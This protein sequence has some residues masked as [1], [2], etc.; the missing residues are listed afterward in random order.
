MSK[1]DA[2]TPPN[3]I[4]TA[5]AATSTNVG[6][7][8]ANSYLNNVNQNTP[9][10][11][12]SYDQTGTYKYTDPLTNASY[13]IPRFTATQSLTPDQT[14]IQQNTQAAQYNLSQAG[15]NQS[16][17]IGRLLDTSFD[18]VNMPWV[19]QGGQASS[20][21][22]LP[23]AQTSFDQGGTIRSNL[24]PSGDI[25]QTYGTDF[26]TDRQRVEDSLMA[27]MNPQ[28][29]I[30]KQALEQQLADQG[31]RY[32]SQAY[33]DAMLTNS[34]QQNDARW[35][36]ISQAGQEQQRMTE[37]EAQ[38]AAF[39]NAAQQQG[40]EQNLGTGS[41][42][43]QAQAQQFQQNAALGT[44]ANAGLAQQVAQ[45]QAGFN[46]SQAAR[47]SAMQEQY[48]Q[49]NQPI[50][51]ISALL[52]GSQVTNPN[53]INTPG[54][55]IPTTDVAGLINNQFSQQMSVY[56]QQ[57]QNFNSLM[58]GVLGLGAG[59]LKGGYLSDRREKDDIDRIATV[60]AASDEGEKKELPIYQYSYKDDPAST[61]HVGP[62][63]QDVEKIKPSAVSNVGGKKYIKPAQ[64]MGSILRAA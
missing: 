8:I 64:V 2:P 4:A 10:G 28:L 16:Y 32:G 43:N 30:Q 1:P 60:F 44:F 13:D 12:L 55:Q 54:S 62:M 7:A 21:T 47:G 5:G 41:F 45:A 36:A 15:R 26:S 57:S 46:A 52:S 58:G 37:E 19:P 24:A 20:I 33:N 38:R 56:G 61:R 34:Q 42:A 35:G 3:P 25:T 49:R 6:T 31:I 9:T 40:Y 50:Q 27:R 29:N 53:F 51:E 18:P 14:A 59:A 17:N 48:A 39:Q 23:K 22:N 11:S 63:A